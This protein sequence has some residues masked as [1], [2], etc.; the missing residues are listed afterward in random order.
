MYLLDANVFIQSY[1]A[2]YGFDIAPGF[3][4]WLSRGGAV[5]MLASVRIIKDE[6]DVGQDELTGWA[7]DHAPLFLAMDAATQPTLAHLAR[8]T[9]SSSTGYT[10]AAQ[11]EFLASGD[12]QLVA[13]AHAYN[14]TVVTYEVPAPGSKKKIKFPDA[15]RA[16][17]VP[18]TGPYAMLREES[19]RF[20]LEA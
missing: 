13:Y 18:C 7:V 14:H 19:A 2:H 10:Q 15:C 9:T 11:A 8:W 3:W 5:G 12:Y 16:L 4:E 17:D 1:R 20:V 6:L